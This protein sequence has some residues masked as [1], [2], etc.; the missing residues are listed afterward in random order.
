MMNQSELATFADANV[1][2]ATDEAIYVFFSSVFLFSGKVAS[3][4]EN[5]LFVWKM[6][7]P[8]IDRNGNEINPHEIQLKFIKYK[9]HFYAKH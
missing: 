9:S 2:F 7:R 8:P 4:F 3:V 6:K 1:N 5:V